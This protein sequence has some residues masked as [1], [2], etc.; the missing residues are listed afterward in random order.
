MENLD[1]LEQ[2][3][4]EYSLS[5]NWDKAVE[6]NQQIIEIDKTNIPA[7]NRLGKVYLAQNLKSKAEKIFKS[8]LKID[9]N[10]KVAKKN[11]LEPS[12]HIS[13]AIDTSNLIK[14]P[15]TSAYTN[16]KISG[17]SVK[18]KDLRVGHTLKV[19]VHGKIS[20]YDEKDNFVGYLSV[21]IASKIIKNKI[22]DQEIRVSVI[23]KKRGVISVLVKTGR[24]IFNSPKSDPVPFI[25]EGEEELI[26]DEIDMTTTENQTDVKA[27]EM[28]GGMIEDDNEEEETDDDNDLSEQEDDDI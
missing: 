20:L 17:K 6:T 12:E 23:G 5:N 11:I 18:A 3:A 7:L 4:I 25:G 16:I 9:P 13:N 27:R 14:E 1:K 2:I 10:N 24:P 8:V 15:G 21:D 22:K 19:K 28:V 26:E